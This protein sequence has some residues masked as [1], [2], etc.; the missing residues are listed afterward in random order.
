M[1]T[2]EAGGK[3]VEGVSRRRSG[4]ARTVWW[5]LGSCRRNS[6]IVGFALLGI[7]WGW[8]RNLKRKTGT[9]RRKEQA[10]RYSERMSE[11]SEGCSP[12]TDFGA[13]SQVGATMWSARGKISVAIP[14][15]PFT[16]TARAIIR[17]FR[18]SVEF[19][20]DGETTAELCR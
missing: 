2:N 3:T 19:G 15:Q 1:L 10:A 18:D 11:L 13:L 4:F 16:V 14:I 20:V 8:E 17:P 6:G 7:G 12:E 5:R 9:L